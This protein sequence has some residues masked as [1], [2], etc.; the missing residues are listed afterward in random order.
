MKYKS[1]NAPA[2]LFHYHCHHDDPS[3]LSHSLLLLLPLLMVYLLFACVSAFSSPNDS[4]L[5]AMAPSW[6]LML[7]V[8]M[9]MAVVHAMR[10]MVP[11][12]LLT[13]LHSYCV[14]HASLMPLRLDVRRTRL[15]S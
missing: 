9:A 12:W 7:M 13:T 15:D 3:H 6:Y 5:V 8:V 1:L 4:M 11:I 14:Y 10:V 2:Y